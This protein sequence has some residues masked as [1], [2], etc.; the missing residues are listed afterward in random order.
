MIARYGIERSINDPDSRAH[1]YAQQAAR[2]GDNVLGMART[3][4]SE[5]ATSS[6]LRADHDTSQH[7]AHFTRSD[8]RTRSSGLDVTRARTFDKRSP[9][10]DPFRTD[11]GAFTQGKSSRQISELFWIGKSRSQRWSSTIRIPDNSSTLHYNTPCNPLVLVLKL[12]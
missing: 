3:S 5:Q 12:T 4:V 11:D 1:K 6:T 2:R 10:V 8:S 7:H 9:P